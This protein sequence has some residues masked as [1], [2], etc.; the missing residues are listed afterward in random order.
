LTYGSTP[1]PA[2]AARVIAALRDFGAPLHDVTEQDLSSPRVGLHIA[3][4]PIRVDVLT[5]ISG[6]DFR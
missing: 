4:A 5:E 6:V 1:R 2:N 3:V